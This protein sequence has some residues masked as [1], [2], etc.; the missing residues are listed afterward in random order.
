MKKKRDALRLLGLLSAVLIIFLPC[1]VTALFP[2]PAGADDA[3]DAR[4]LAERAQFTLET[5]ARAPEMDAFRNLVRNARGVFIAPQILKGAFVIGASGG[6]GVLVSRDRLKDQWAGPAFYTIGSASF[7][8]QI[9][10]NASEVV[11][12]AMTTGE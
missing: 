6:S 5:F 4:H 7:G 11:L 12:L 10:G 2:A 1:A 9:G 3:M 8:F